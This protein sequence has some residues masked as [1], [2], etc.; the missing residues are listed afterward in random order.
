MKILKRHRDFKS[1]DSACAFF[2]KMSERP[3]VTRVK[4]VKIPNGLR[5][6]YWQ[7]R[8]MR[9]DYFLINFQR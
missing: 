4:F 6:Y 1:A 8:K 2:N 7:D 5:V 3:Y 9:D